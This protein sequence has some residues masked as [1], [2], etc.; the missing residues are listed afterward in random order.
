MYKK[1]IVEYKEITS[2]IRPCYSAKP[3]VKIIII[4][5]PRIFLK[6]KGEEYAES[7]KNA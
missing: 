5:K 4:K 3:I 7:W 6:P 2:K 1:P